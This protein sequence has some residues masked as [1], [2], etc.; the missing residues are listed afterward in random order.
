MGVFSSS[1]STDDTGVSAFR[2]M[3]GVEVVDWNDESVVL[4]DAVCVC[5]ATENVSDLEHVG[6]QCELTTIKLMTF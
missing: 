4:V 2:V 6:Q 5:D 1:L 3:R